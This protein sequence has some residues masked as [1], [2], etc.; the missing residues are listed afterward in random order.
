MRRRGAEF[1]APG[2][3]GHVDYCVADFFKYVCVTALG[4]VGLIAYAACLALVLWWMI[5]AGTVG[6]ALGQDRLTLPFMMRQ[7][8]FYGSMA[9]IVA[10]P[11]MGISIMRG[12]NA[13]MKRPGDERHWWRRAHA[14]LGFHLLAVAVCAAA[15]ML[16]C[17]V[18]TCLGS[19]GESP[20][21]AAANGLFWGSCLGVGCV[22]IG[23]GVAA[24]SGR[25]E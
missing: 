17:V 23:A 7:A 1:A 18:V 13:R 19:P 3:R 24:L 4:Y 12:I 25:A 10:A 5:P 9:S 14:S 15:V 20:R 16:I 8:W 22:A 21:V 2:P 11:L 6:G